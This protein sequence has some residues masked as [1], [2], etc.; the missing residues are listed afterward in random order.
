[1][2]NDMVAAVDDGDGFIDYDE[3]VK[4][5]K[6]YWLKYCQRICKTR[7]H[8]KYIMLIEFVAL[9]YL[10]GRNTSLFYSGIDI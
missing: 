3:F 8:M 5:I 9:T 6:K 4:M 7:P 2:V 10:F 1:M